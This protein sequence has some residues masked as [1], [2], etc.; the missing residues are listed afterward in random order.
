MARKKPPLGVM[1]CFLWYEEHPDPTIAELLGRFVDVSA[2]IARRREAGLPPDD[3]LLWEIG[4]IPD[5]P[6]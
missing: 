5:P 1:P 4:L 6:S 3:V 2:A